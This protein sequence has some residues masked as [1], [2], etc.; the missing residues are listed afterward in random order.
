VIC[1]P[2]ADIVPPQLAGSFAAFIAARL[3][4]NGVNLAI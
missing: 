3:H 1:T 2:A 4:G